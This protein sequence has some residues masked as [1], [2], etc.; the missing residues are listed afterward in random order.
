MLLAV[1]GSREILI[2]DGWEEI[3][4]EHLERA[5]VLVHGACPH[6][7]NPKVHG[8]KSI[9]AWA[10]DVAL[11]YSHLEI[12]RF[13]ADW[14]LGRKGG[15]IRNADMARWCVEH[16]IKQKQLLA[17]PGN[18]GTASCRS[19]FRKVGIRVESVLELLLRGIDP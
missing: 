13:P 7:K 4:R 8:S 1:T 17:F 14:S 16:E 15:P 2:G 10:D 9:D 5:T 12:V 3:L 19:E 6:P 18:N 11:G